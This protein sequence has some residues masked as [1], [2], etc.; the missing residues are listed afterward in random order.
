[1]AQ[2]RPSTVVDSNYVMVSTAW[3]VKFGGFMNMS[4]FLICLSLVKDGL[5]RYLV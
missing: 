3:S 5:E 4:G 2:L 1:M